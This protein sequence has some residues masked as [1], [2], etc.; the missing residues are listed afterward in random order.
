MIALLLCSLWLLFGYSYQLSEPIDR[1]KT[2]AVV[3]AGLLPQSLTTIV[4]R[5]GAP[6]RKHKRK[7]TRSTKMV[8]WLC[9][10]TAA[11]DS[12]YSLASLSFHFVSLKIWI[13]SHL[14]HVVVGKLLHKNCSTGGCTGFQAGKDKAFCSWRDGWLFGWLIASLED[15]NYERVGT[16]DKLFLMMN[17]NKI[18][19]HM[20]SSCLQIIIPMRYWRH[21]FSQACQQNY[22]P[23]FQFDLRIT[24]AIS[25][26][27]LTTKRNAIDQ[28][29]NKDNLRDDFYFIWTC[30]NNKLTKIT[31]IGWRVGQNK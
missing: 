19:Y 29:A 3:L 23:Y 31:W 24:L 22:S 12:G 25:H 18:H 21:S 6:K 26:E 8:R 28:I 27:Q 11:V 15:A 7:N 17:N 1:T 10:R 20:D 30:S 13:F 4:I 14:V 9:C 2:E 5:K 16:W